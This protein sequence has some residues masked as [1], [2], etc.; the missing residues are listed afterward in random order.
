MEDYLK[1]IFSIT[2]DEKIKS[3]IYRLTSNQDATT[4]LDKKIISLL[5]IGINSDLIIRLTG[6]SFETIKALRL[7][8]FPE[9]DD[10]K[11]L[12]KNI[13]SHDYLTLL[14]TSIKLISS[15]MT[16]EQ[17]VKEKQLKKI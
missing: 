7:V 1:I 3:E 16:S 2:D 14:A 8:Y 11:N 6:A 15:V 13:N 10:K 5:S 12:V 4:E 17:N 9:L